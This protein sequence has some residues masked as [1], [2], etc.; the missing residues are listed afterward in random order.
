MKLFSVNFLHPLGHLL[1]QQKILPRRLFRPVF[2]R[3]RSSNNADFPFSVDFFGIEYL[4][5]LNNN[6]DYNIYFYGAFEKPLLN[7]LSDTMQAF[8]A[9]EKTGV[10]VD[11]GAN[12][13]QHSLYMSRCSAQ[14][15]AFEPYAPVRNRLMQQISHNKI[16]NIQ[17]HP[18]GLSNENTSLPFFAPTGNNA[19]I[20]SFDASS[21]DK[22]NKQIGEL[23]L[24]RGDDFFTAANPERIDLVK[25]DVEGFEKPALEGL[26]KTLHKYRPLIVCEITYGKALS[27]QSREE[28]LQLLPENY[29]LL[30][31]NKRKADG[32]K[33]R[34]RDA[35]TRLSGQYEIIDYKNMLKSG[36][37]DVI[38]CPNE[39]Y[40]SL[41]RT[42]LQKR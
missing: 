17:V 40:Q 38:A 27:I 14:V 15:H 13:G 25:I 32:S 18:L 5:N 6:I 23:E 36:Q 10:F 20:G 37:D 7:F 24:I 42:N 21:M 34:R 22:G 39:K 3:L 29:T 2:K 28:I 41:P 9:E 33:A 1:W 31:F 8:V 11:I 16:E 19:G 35:R 26:Q 30:A 12:V 4:G